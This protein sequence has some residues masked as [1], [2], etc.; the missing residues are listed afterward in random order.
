MTLS[1]TINVFAKDNF[2]DEKEYAKKFLK[3]MGHDVELGK[4]IPLYNIDDELEAL[5]ISINDGGY[6]IINTNDLSVPEFSLKT[7]NPYSVLND[8]SKPIYNGPLKYYK[9]EDGQLV[10]LNTNK[11][12][13]KDKLTKNYKKS[14]SEKE[15]NINQLNDAYSIESN[16]S[17]TSYG[18]RIT[19]TL[20]TWATSHYCGVDGAAILLMYYDDYYNDNTVATSYES[21]SALTGLLAGTYIPDAG[22]SASQVGSGLSLYC[23]DRYLWYRASLGRAIYILK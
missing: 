5:S 13:D 10:S 11:K 3:L 16:Y 8:T 6:V 12:V 23:G 19:G 15:K 7:E 21:A 14:A 9:Y 2:S 22:T 1:T 4:A 18:S 20:R 17:S